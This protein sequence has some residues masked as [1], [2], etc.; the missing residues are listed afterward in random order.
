MWFGLAED[1]IMPMC[2]GNVRTHL[3]LTSALIC[4]LAALSWS[5]GKDAHF[6]GRAPKGDRKGA[7][8]SAPFS[9]SQGRGKDG[10]QGQPSGGTSEEPSSSD[11]MG[12]VTSA[13]EPLGGGQEK[14]EA[15]LGFELLAG[16]LQIAK[17]A[18]VD[19]S[20]RYLFVVDQSVSMQNVLADLQKGFGNLRSEDFPANA[21]IGVISTLI[22]EDPSADKLKM[23]PQ[24]KSYVGNEVEPGFLELVTQKAI[25]R[26]TGQTT[27]DQKYRSRFGKPGCRNGWFAPSE[28]NADGDSCLSAHTQ[29]VQSPSV[30]EPGMI[31]VQQYMLRHGKSAFESAD[32][33]N[34]IFVS[35]TEYPGCSRQDVAVREH[36]TQEFWGRSGQFKVGSMLDHFR[37]HTKAGV[38]QSLV[39]H[40]IVPLGKADEQLKCRESW[41]DDWAQDF[42]ADLS[43]DSGGTLTDICTSTDYSAPLQK[44]FNNEN[45]IQKVFDRDAGVPENAQ[46]DSVEIDGVRSADFEVLDKGIFLPKLDANREHSIRIIYRVPVQPTTL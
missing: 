14:T 3:A 15:G 20:R 28:T 6:A 24:I 33:V 43:R 36:T 37:K 8:S 41:T 13:G 34:V 38:M 18:A 21:K 32:D 31:A 16:E 23:A 40:A 30:C 44:I 22:A 5:C 39:F 42:Y 1:K 17:P 25:E 9:D 7:E 19:R 29:I 46:V 11:G 35:D 26:F 4:G 12:P 45:S 2:G 10:L 27:V